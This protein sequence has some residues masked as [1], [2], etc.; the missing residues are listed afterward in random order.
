MPL[1]YKLAHAM[2]AIVA[3]RKVRAGTKALPLLFESRGSPVLQSFVA[4][5]ER[6]ESQERKYL[7]KDTYHV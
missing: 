4:H 3:R 7:T 6:K 1:L 5:L 2:T